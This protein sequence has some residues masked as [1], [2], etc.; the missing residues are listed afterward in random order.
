[1]KVFAMTKAPHLF[2]PLAKPGF[3]PLR[4][5]TVMSAMS[6]SFAS[7]DRF[8]TPEMAE[9]YRKRAAGGAG[10]ILTEGT[11]I[12]KSGDGWVRAPYISSDAHAE[13]WRPVVDAVHAEGGAIACQ[14][15]HMGRISHEDF[16]GAPP[17]SSTARA[18]GGVNRQNNK[19]YGEPRALAAEDMPAL[20]RLFADAAR[21][22]LAV[23]FDA[24][25]LHAAN[26]YIVD[27]FLDGQVNDRTDAYGGS[28]ENRCRFML[29][30]VDA[31]V[32]AVPANRVM[33][34]ISPSRFM[35]GLYEWPDMEA[36]IAYLV[37]ELAKRGLGAL[38]VSCANSV[39]ADT[40]GRVVRMVRPLWP[41]VLIAGASLTVEGAESEVAAGVID[42][43]TWG[44][45][46][47][48]NPDLAAKMQAG[49]DLTTF[50]DAMRGTLV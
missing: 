33:A 38:D 22:A 48:A 28:V 21:R 50:E 27:Q 18:A 25:E 36:M 34:R 40:S 29:E 16:T 4:N 2:S 8:A 23:G 30:L 47:I 1:V 10:L 13:A 20:Y 11:V 39:Y 32:A 5:R 44:R 19:P 46:F 24:V 49:S 15:W 3:I 35:G 37:P 26:G 31:V 12:D 45:L 9:Y 6:R 14:L 7:E 17:V 42:A 41:G 43:V